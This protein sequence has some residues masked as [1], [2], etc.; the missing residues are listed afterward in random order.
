M[1]GA[2]LVVLCAPVRAIGTLVREMAPFLKPGC[3]ITD[4][5]SVKASLVR[6]IEPLV[7]D[8]IFF[9]GAHPIA[10]GEKSGF[11][12][13]SATLFEGA[14][15]IVTPTEKTDPDALKQITALWEQVG[16]RVSSMGVDEHDYIFGAV[17]HMPHMVVY[18]LMNTLGSLKSDN[19]DQVT[20]FSGAGLK[21]ITRIASGDPVMWRDICLSNRDS[22]LHCIDRFQETLSHIR[23]KIDRGEGESLVREFKTANKHRLDLV[24]H[25]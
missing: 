23:D 3:L 19:H 17:S 6:E 13:S 1:E 2:D 22:V 8:G 5:G 12:V 15:C 16:M 14:R 4:V 25:A 10:G 24:G 18:A 21:D 9:V 20:S 11:R 7:P